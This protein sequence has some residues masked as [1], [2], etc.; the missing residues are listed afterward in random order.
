MQKIMTKPIQMLQVI[1]N[2]Q[3]KQSF[4]IK[5]LLHKQAQ[6]NKISLLHKLIFCIQN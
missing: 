4:L 2:L 3:I 5:V 1:N 6:Y